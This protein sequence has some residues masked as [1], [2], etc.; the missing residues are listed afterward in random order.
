VLE[1]ST[2]RNGLVA[3]LEDFVSLVKAYP[4]TALLW[5]GSIPVWIYSWTN[6]LPA[7]R[8]PMFPLQA[9]FLTGIFVV[10]NPVR[11]GRKN[12]REGCFWIAVGCSVPAHAVILVGLYWD[13]TIPGTVT[14][15]WNSFA[16][17]ILVASALEIVVLDAIFNYFRP[18]P[19]SATQE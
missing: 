11:A 4:A 6:G 2:S 15:L 16:S 18:V 19:A 14:F 12:L 3:F 8:F 10:E 5:V 17:R 13:R 1:D 7:G 9:Y